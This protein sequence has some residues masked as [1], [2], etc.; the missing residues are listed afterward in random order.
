[1]DEIIKKQNLDLGNLIFVLTLVELDTIENKIS[2]S[3]SYIMNLSEFDEVDSQYYILLNDDTVLIK[4]P[5]LKM[6]RLNKDYHQLSKHQMEGLKKRLFVDNTPFRYC[7][8]HP[9]LAIVDIGPS[10]TLI[11][12]Y[13]DSWGYPKEYRT[14]PYTVNGVEIKKEDIKV[15]K[16]P[17]EEFLN[18]PDSL[19]VYPYLDSLEEN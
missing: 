3:L 1:M 19:F 8:Y 17:L 12:F 14:V 16:I 10:S 6:L 7:L 18:S 5:A 2:F 11:N 4:G 13:Y 9:V 15:L